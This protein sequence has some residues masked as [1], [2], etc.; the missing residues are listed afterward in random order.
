MDLHTL[1]FGVYP[2]IALSVFLL[3]SLIRFDR[4]QYTWKADSSQLLD[5][6]QLRLG[7]NLFHIGVLA[8]FVGHFVGL[9]TPRRAFLALGVSDMAHQYIAIIAGA[10]FGVV[11]MIGGV[12]LWRRRM[13]NPRIRATSRFMDIFILDWLLVTLGV[14]L[15]TIPVSISHALHGNV[16]TMIALAEWAQSVLTLQPKPLLLQTVPLIFKIHLFLGLSVFFLFPFTR[17][18]H[19]WSVPLSYLARPY[20]IV[21]TKY[22]RYR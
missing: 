10:A 2:Y 4:E 7:S 9:L 5:R 13:F 18:I 12:L 8:L 19:V 20:Q 1:L 14:G 15:S 21:R 6:K 22:V 3:G 17:L 11:C 16:Q